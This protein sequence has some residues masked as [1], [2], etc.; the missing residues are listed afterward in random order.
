MGLIVREESLSDAEAVKNVLTSAFET[1]AEASIVATVRGAD[2]A[3]FTLVAEQDGTVVDFT[4]SFGGSLLLPNQ[5]FD[6]AL[7]RADNALYNAKANGRNR[8]EFK[9]H[10]VLAG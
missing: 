8:V 2:D 6:E 3:L 1:S 7:T 4:A 5:P 10:L 9:R